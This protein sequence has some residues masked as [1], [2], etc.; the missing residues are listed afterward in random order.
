MDSPSF[1]GFDAQLIELVDSK[2]TCDIKN[3]AWLTIV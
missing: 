3:H 2:L 1:E